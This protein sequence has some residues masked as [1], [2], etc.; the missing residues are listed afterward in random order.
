MSYYKHC[1]Y[2]RIS[3]VS[4]FDAT[5]TIECLK[6]FKNTEPANVRVELIQSDLRSISVILR[7]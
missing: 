4:T 2:S 6:N 3:T 1:Q 5:R 7:Q